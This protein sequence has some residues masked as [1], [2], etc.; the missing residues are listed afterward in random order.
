MHVHCLQATHTLLALAM[1][2]ETPAVGTPQPPCCSQRTQQFLGLLSQQPILSLI[3]RLTPPPPSSPPVAWIPLLCLCSPHCPL[4]LSLLPPFRPA[5]TFPLPFLP[6]SPPPALPP[7][8]PIH[9]LPTFLLP[10]LAPSAPPLPPTWS[11]PTLTISLAHKRTVVLQTCFYPFFTCQK[12]NYQIYC[13]PCIAALS[14]AAHHDTTTSLFL[15][16]QCHD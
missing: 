15:P 14:L 6:F 5:P 11:P 9:V 12:P 10:T 3:I 4:S 16:Q 1:W 8:T 7:C 2:V 13:P